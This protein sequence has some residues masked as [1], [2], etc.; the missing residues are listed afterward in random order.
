MPSTY[1]IVEIKEKD[2]VAN[3]VSLLINTNCRFTVTDDLDDYAKSRKPN[4]MKMQK[5]EKVVR[6]NPIYQKLNLLNNQMLNGTV[7]AENTVRTIVRHAIPSLNTTPTPLFPVRSYKRGLPKRS[8]PQ[9]TEV[10]KVMRSAEKSPEVA[11]TSELTIAEPSIEV[12]EENDVKPDLLT[13]LGG[14]QGVEN[15]STLEAIL[16]TAQGP[17]PEQETPSCKVES[18]DEMEPESE[19]GALDPANLLK[20]YN[21]SEAM[22]NHLTR[23]GV[24]AGLREEVKRKRPNQ[25]FQCKMCRAHIKV[26]GYDYHKRSTHA[27][28]HSEILRYKC[29]YEGCTFK[30]RHR[31]DICRH[32]RLAHGLDPNYLRIPECMTEEEG[33]KLRE[34]VLKCF[35]EMA[36]AMKGERTQMRLAD[37]DAAY[38]LNA[39]CDDDASPV[40]Q[41]E[42]EEEEE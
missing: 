8:L 27:I 33:I 2:E 18:S 13:L 25:S 10:I 26:R 9:T 3:V 11:T 15:N 16:K 21:N 1:V 23:R 42:E 38:Q 36:P 29:P 19:L 40:K 28:I 34:V 17:Q 39:N 20:F 4:L 12:E 7:P 6:K 14:D 22:R 32:L 35:P 30:N 5:D 24:A 37:V 31:S 41:E